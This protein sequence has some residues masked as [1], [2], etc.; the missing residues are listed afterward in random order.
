MPIPY[1]Y[2]GDRLTP[3]D[4][5]QITAGVNALQR[6][7]SGRGV[8]I[9]SSAAGL[10]ILGDRPDRAIQEAAFEM[11]A[12]NAGD[13]D[14]PAFSPAVIDGHYF[15]N[16]FLHKRALTI[17]TPES[18]FEGRWVVTKE[19]IAAGG[20]GRVWTMGIFPARI[21]NTG[22][23]ADSAEIADGETY[24][25]PATDGPAEVLFEEEGSGTHLC[26]IRF[27]GPST[28]GIKKAAAAA[29]TNLTLNGTQ[30]VD[31]VSLAVDSLCL[32]KSQSVSADKGLYKVQSG[33]WLFLGSP[34]FV[35]ITGGTLYG[36]TAFINVGTSTPNYVGLGAFY[37]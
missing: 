18:G 13:D 23:P 33:D 37:K 17:R 6:P 12:V 2:R 5:N 11:T 27:T 29:T 9:S 30:T 3:A 26:L 15:E 7:F 20:V 35:V 1:K 22:D 19:P 34:D 8:R 31:G 10:S 28:A 16:S 25:V 14:L 4:I 32:A 24:L 36:Q 21:H